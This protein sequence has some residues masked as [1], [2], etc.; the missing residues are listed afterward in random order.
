MNANNTIK[1]LIPQAL[2]DNI[3][4]EK[5]A[6][7]AAKIVK[8]FKEANEE[9]YAR[10]EESDTLSDELAAECVS[11]IQEAALAAHNH[12]LEMVKQHGGTDEIKR[13]QGPESH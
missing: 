10:L 8:F 5:R 9:L 7:V 1:S 13:P 12:H 2:I 3:P 11:R 6:H 4:Q